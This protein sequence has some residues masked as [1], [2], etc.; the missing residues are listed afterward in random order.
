MWTQL[1]EPTNSS[2]CIASAA[3]PAPI[4]PMIPFRVAIDNSTARLLNASAGST[5]NSQLNSTRSNDSPGDSSVPLR[6]TSD[7]SPTSSTPASRLAAA[8]SATRAIENVA[9]A[10]ILPTNTSR[11]VHDLASTI[12]QVP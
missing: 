4:T 11:R 6:L 2:S 7:W 9:A 10:R 3:R 1:P 5:H 8:V 12:F